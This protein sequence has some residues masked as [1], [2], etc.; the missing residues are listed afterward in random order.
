M[1]RR[2]QCIWTGTLI[3]AL[4]WIERKLVLDG[5]NEHS[6]VQNNEKMTRE[7]EDL[8]AKSAMLRCSIDELTS[9]VS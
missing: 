2:N 7:L 9:E 4:P 6:T 8:K 1:F 5:A 3:F